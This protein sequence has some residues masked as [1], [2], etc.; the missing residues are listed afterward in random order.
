MLF[1]SR[2]S[3]PRVSSDA[4]INQL[5]MDLYGRNLA[6]AHEHCKKA[7]LKDPSNAPITYIAA[8]LRSRLEGD[9][10]T[11]LKLLDSAL[12]AGAHPGYFEAGTWG[13][14]CLKADLLAKLGRPDDALACF[15]ASPAPASKLTICHETLPRGRHS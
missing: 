9:D 1:R 4:V 2:S 13:T 7:L 8:F 6:A 11:A 14:V 10:Q 3:L 12:E 15:R 5:Y